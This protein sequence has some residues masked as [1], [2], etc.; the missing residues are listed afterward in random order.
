MTYLLAGGGLLSFN[1]GFAIWIAISLIVFLGIMIKFALPPIMKALD[2]REANI[3]DSLESA[4]K[5][6]AKAEQISKDNDKA[7][8]EA[9]AKAQKI[10]KDALEEADILRSERISKAKDDAAQILEQ[11]KAT[12]EQEK[13]QALA[14]LRKEVAKLAVQSASIIIDAELDN[15]K[16]NKLVDNFIT[17]LSKN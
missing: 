14:E 15:D 3:K 17:D 2:E 7:L 10:R 9:E 13:K 4:H 12:I 5:A 6:L 16:N 1:T 11:A 8:R